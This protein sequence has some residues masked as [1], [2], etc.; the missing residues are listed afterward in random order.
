M[1]NHIIAKT[2]EEWY[3]LANKGDEQGLFFV[4]QE[5]IRKERNTFRYPPAFTQE[6]MQ[7]KF[8][9]MYQNLANYLG[10]KVYATGSSL[11]GYWRTKEEEDM[12]CEK[13]GCKPKYSDL[14]FWVDRPITKEEIE[15][16]NKILLPLAPYSYATWCNYVEFY[17]QNTM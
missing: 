10:E 16:I 2:R 6:E 14:D 4:R 11:R 1:H 12:I 17:P 15:Q 3:A 7:P 13:Y 8:V 5:N 9:E